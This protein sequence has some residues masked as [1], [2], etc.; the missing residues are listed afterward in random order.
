MK[1]PSEFP[2]Q[3]KVLRAQLGLSQ[4]DL[5]REVGVSFATLNRWENGKSNPSKLAMAQL[6]K[7]CSRMTRKGDLVQNPFA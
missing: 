3:I 5:A 1:V 4:E 7:F 2:V 6:E